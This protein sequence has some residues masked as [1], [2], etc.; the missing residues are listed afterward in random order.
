MKR[1]I[2]MLLVAGFLLACNSGNDRK[3]TLTAEPSKEGHADHGE[4]AAGLVLNNGAKW[5][6]DSI[7][8]LNVSLLQA[9]VSTGKEEKPENYVQTAGKLRDGLNKLVEECKMKG[10]DHDALHQWLEPLLEKANELRKASSP[11]NAALI[12][13]EIDNH[14]QLF[15]QYFE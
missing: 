9:I 7:T 1:I 10:A 2:T 8:L 6:A 11:E 5:K 14:I 15:P 13:N 12:L 4:K 3:N